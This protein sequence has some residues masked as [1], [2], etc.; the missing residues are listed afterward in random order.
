MRPVA[1][2]C[3]CVNWLAFFCEDTH[4]CVSIAGTLMLSYTCVLWRLAGVDHSEYQCVL[5][6]L[7]NILHNHFL[8]S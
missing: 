7:F 3:V 4:L 5:L 6:G 8:L 2:V 1:G